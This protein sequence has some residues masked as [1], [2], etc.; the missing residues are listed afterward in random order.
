M[1]RQQTKSEN[2]KTFL[3]YRDFIESGLVSNR[4]TLDRWIESNDFPKPYRLG[5]NTLAWRQDEV[6]AWVA[7]RK[8]AGV[9]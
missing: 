3:R 2:K 6:D 7:E 4:T 9:A 5:P 8:R 1:K